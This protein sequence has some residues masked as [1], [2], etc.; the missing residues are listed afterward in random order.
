[1]RMVRARRATCVS[2]ARQV[3]L[4]E[5]AQQFIAHVVEVVQR[6]HQ[7]T[8]RRVPGS[9]GRPVRHVGG[10]Q[11]ATFDLTQAHVNPEL[12]AAQAQIDNLGVHLL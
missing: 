6:M 8:H 9:D 3:A 7:G 10:C 5:A 2:H 11:L 12:L 4:I 1:M